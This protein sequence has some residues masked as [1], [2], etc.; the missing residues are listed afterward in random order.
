MQY[1]QINPELMQL[2]ADYVIARGLPV[3]C[4]PLWI[5]RD[6]EDKYGAAAMDRLQSTQ[7]LKTSVQLCLGA[8][9]YVSEGVGGDRVWIREDRPQQAAA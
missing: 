1:Y 5:A 2:V 3:R 7:T 4:R 9:G 8:L 6:L